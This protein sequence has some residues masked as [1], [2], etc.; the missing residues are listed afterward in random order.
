MAIEPI[1]GFYV[2]LSVLGIISIFGV[3][4]KVF[5]VLSTVIIVVSIALALFSILLYSDVTDLAENFPT[6][7]KLFLLDIDEKIVA[8]FIIGK[9]GNPPIFLGDADTL[10][11]AYGVKNYPEM[12][13]SNYIM[14]IFKEEDIKTESIEMAGTTFQKDFVIEMLKSDQPMKLFNDKMAGENIAGIDG[15]ETDGEFKALLF[16]TLFAGQQES[17]IEQLKKV[18]V[19]PQ[20]TAFKL[21]K[22]VPTKLV[23]KL[24]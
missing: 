19:Y 12:L 21:L 7:D 10:N 11:E 6:E 13:G 16:S 18:F 23:E 17:F 14:F 2:L 20:A 24:M 1:T 5:K 4:K 8:G 3:I 22:Y 9:E 15:V